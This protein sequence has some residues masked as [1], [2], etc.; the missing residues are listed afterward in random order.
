[1]KRTF[2]FIVSLTLL[3]TLCLPGEAAAENGSRV[4]AFGIQENQSK[5]LKKK[6]KAVTKSPT[7]ETVEEGGFA[8]FVARADNC[9][10]IIWHLASAEGTDLLA[11]NA[12]VSFPGLEVKGLG[13]ERLVLD[14][15]PAGL[16]SWNVWAEFVYLDGNLI[17]DFAVLH[18]IS[19]TLAPPTILS[20]PNS[21]NLD[22][23]QSITLQVAAEAE[24]QGLSLRYQWYSNTSNSSS[25]GQSIPEATE[26]SYTPEYSPGTLYYYCAVRTTDGN[27]I[28]SAAK[29]KCAA[30]SY[31]T[32]VTRPTEAATEPTAE[33]PSEQA[34]EPAPVQN[35]GEPT[36]TASTLATWNAGT[37]APEQ[38]LPSVTVPTTTA[39]SRTYART[40][41]LI[42][43]ITAVLALIVAVAL[44]ISLVIYKLSRRK[45][46]KS[47][48]NHKAPKTKQE[49]EDPP[50]KRLTRED[51][52]EWDDLS[53]LDLSY[54]LEDEDVR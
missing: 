39:P 26:S 47:Q 28:S 1:M 13:S 34:T 19:K 10:G 53:D 31:P 45:A 21:V 5:L 44:A 27:S 33:Q 37:E 16:D 2:S 36:G 25:K 46:R 51:D 7:G 4:M 20:H 17:S 11:Q 40:N 38:T 54:Y 35:N 12:Q 15:I 14:N 3:L 29:T 32:A 18:V 42:L 24:G 22:E 8:Q 49:R 41:S 50:K 9:T 52:P 30:V 6:T 23:G 48:R 43:L